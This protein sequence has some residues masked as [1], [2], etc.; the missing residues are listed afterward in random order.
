MDY[1]PVR[2]SDHDFEP[3]PVFGDT[4]CVHIEPDGGKCTWQER[5]HVRPLRVRI[6]RRI[7]GWLR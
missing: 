7:R 3:C 4:F 2:V 1:N 6:V 5:K